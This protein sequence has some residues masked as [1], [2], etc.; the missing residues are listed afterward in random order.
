MLLTTVRTEPVTADRLERV[1][2]SIQRTPNGTEYH[3]GAARN[4]SFAFGV[5]AFTLLWTG[6]IWLQWYL[7]FPWFFIIITG[8]FDLF[9]LFIVADLWCGTTTVITSPGSVRRR[10][11][12]FEIG[13]WRTITSSE[14]AA[15]K[16]QISMQT[17]GRSGTPYY[18]I[19]AMLKNGRKCGLGDGIRNKRQAEWL[20]ERMR[21]ETG[22]MPGPA[23]NPDS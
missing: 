3:F 1:G 14:I 2:I 23:L 5:T 18:E 6:A 4:A 16:L 22:P 12:L 9:M 7:G 20:L 11:S 10:H 13:G 19:K 8:S 15:L 17:S 21:S